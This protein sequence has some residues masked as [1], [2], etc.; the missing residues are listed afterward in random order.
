MFKAELIAN[1]F[2]LQ[3]RNKLCNIR[4]CPKLPSKRVTLFEENR[5]SR[6][7]KTLATIFLCTEHYGTKMP[8]FIT[9][10]NK[11]RETGKVVEKRVQ[12]VGFITY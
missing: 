8:A 11:A 6:D 7:K 5:I 12:D 3:R 9:E 10:I 2:D 4:G 1:A